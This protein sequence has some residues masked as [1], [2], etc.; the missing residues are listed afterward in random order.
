[1]KI[2]TNKFLAWLSTQTALMRYFVIA[3][4]FHVLILFVLGSIK[5][6]TSIP[7]ITA[8]FGGAAPPPANEDDVD[9]FA[10]L[11]DF[12]YNGPTLG[13]GGGTPGKGPGGVPTAAGTTP[14]EYRASITA[15]DKNVA[16]TAVAE[17]I[18][19]VSDS[20]NAVARLQG[21]GLGGVAA[22][23]TGFGEGKIGT[24]GIRGPGGGG[25]GQRM[26]PMRAQ[27]IRAGGGSGDTEKTVM[28]ALRWLKENQKSD[29]SWGGPEALSA[30]GLLCFLGHGE[31]PDS[32]E[33]GL[34]VTKAISYLVTIVGS[35]GYVKSKNMYSQGAVTLALSEAYGMTQSP[36]V[37][38]PLERMI[39]GNVQSQNV[40]KTNPIHQGGWH[41]S[42][43]MPSADTSVSGWIIMGLKSARIAGM[44]V[45]D[46]SYKQASEY[47]WKVYDPNGGFGYSGP[48]RSG[49]MTAVGTLCQMFL[50]HGDHNKIKKALDYLK[51]QTVDWQNPAGGWILYNWYYTTQAMFQGGGSYWEYWNKQI[52][53]TLVKNQAADGHW[54]SPGKQE[55]GHGPVYATTLCCLSLEVYYRYL[56]I[57]QEIERKSLPKAG[58]P[59]PSATTK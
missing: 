46:E 1:M 53:D 40:K 49:A 54:D 17:V 6:A 10:A 50:E 8:F 12:E 32:E 51:T 5:I 27:K 38:E 23:T 39:Q 58:A 20:A 48:N 33:F 44:S 7:R 11:R 26:G 15:V 22:P 3:V 31:T 41:Y 9:P 59:L 34:T 52:R 36:V 42:P 57:Y 30:L 14:T 13:G 45:P 16:D 25:F 29:G 2:L 56:P 43:Q 19:V 37:K 47:L 4:M 55:S 35:D 21:S 18:G 28:A 24:A